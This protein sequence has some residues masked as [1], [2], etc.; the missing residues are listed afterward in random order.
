MRLLLCCYASTSCSE[1][2]ELASAPQ[3][4]QTDRQGRKEKGEGKAGVERGKENAQFAHQ[5]KA[6]QADEEWHGN[7]LHR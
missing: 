2:E 1:I 7:T 5:S 3:D 4:R 6:L